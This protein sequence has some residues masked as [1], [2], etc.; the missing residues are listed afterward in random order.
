[1]DP[2]FPYAGHE[3]GPLWWSLALAVV[4]ITTFALMG[5]FLLRATHAYDI[6]PS[7]GEDAAP[8]P[9]PRHNA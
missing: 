4:A 2:T 7:G 6:E 3:H 1:M 5:V 8:D 9:T